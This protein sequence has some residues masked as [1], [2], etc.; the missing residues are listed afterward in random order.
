MLDK[1]HAEHSLRLVTETIVFNLLNNNVIN[2]KTAQQDKSS[3]VTLVKT[4]L[5]A[6]ATNNTTEPPTHA[7]TAQPVN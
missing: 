2:A 1:L 5:L 3:S 4:K 6:L 7:K